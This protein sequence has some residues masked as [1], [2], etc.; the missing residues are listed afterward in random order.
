MKKLKQEFDHQ[1]EKLIY[2]AQLEFFK[3]AK[4]IHDLA[5]SNKSKS[6]GIFTFYGELHNTHSCHC[7]MKKISIIAQK[8]AFSPNSEYTDYFGALNILYEM[9]DFFGTKRIVD[10]VLL[11]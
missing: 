8:H 1:Y 4:L 7:N 2:L 11:F 10:S 3:L 6:F 5:D 9:L